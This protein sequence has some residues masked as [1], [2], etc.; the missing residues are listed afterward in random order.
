LYQ[1]PYGIQ[2]QTLK[3]DHLFLMTVEKQI[4]QQIEILGPRD[5][6]QRGMSL[7]FPNKEQRITKS[8]QE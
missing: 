7:K 6:E 5:G 8:R 4:D 1:Y 2:S 3:D